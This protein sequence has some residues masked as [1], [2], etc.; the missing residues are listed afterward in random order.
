M[1]FQTDGIVVRNQRIKSLY[2]A[3]TIHCPPIAEEVRPG[4]FVMLKVSKD[5]SPLLRRPFSIYRSYR[6]DHPERRK[7]GSL[8]IVYKKVGRGTQKMTEFRSGQKVDLIGPLG[9]RFSLPPFPSSKNIILV[10]GGVGIVTLYS[11]AE[12]ARGHKLFVFIGGRT[13]KD[14]LCEED[15]RNAGASKILIATED[16]SQGHQGTVIDLFLSWQKGH[17]KI[18]PEYIYSCGPVEMLK[19]LANAIESQK[20][21]CQI[22]LEARMGCG[23]GACWGCV[24]KTND[25]KKPY[26]R[27]CKEGPVFNLRDI[28]WE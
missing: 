28:V 19:A 1:T 13:A 21:L 11:L 2:F 12:A 14:I 5:R 24:V 4:Q 10:G 3:L 9:N 25:P 22:S 23:F 26:Q 15:F 16:G 8:L 20:A 17:N 6:L 7:R 18:E 27:V